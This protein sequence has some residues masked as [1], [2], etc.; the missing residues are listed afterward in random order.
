MVLP[1]GMATS[2][3]VFGLRPMPRLRFLTRKTPKPRS[4][5]RSPWVSASRIASK[6]AF[7]ASFAFDCEISTAP[8]T[9]R[10][11]SALIMNPSTFSRAKLVWR[12]ASCQA[13]AGP[14]FLS[15]DQDL[16]GQSD[17]A[18]HL[19]NGGDRDVRHA[20]LAL[21]QPEETCGFTAHAHRNHHRLVR[22]GRSQRVEQKGVALTRAQ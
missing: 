17:Q 2:T 1:G 6:T 7:T 16:E 19:L 20:L 4:S 5:M 11:R 21:V 3:P 10:T 9:L 15:Q 8:I 14:D 13:G 22:R 12:G 18:Y